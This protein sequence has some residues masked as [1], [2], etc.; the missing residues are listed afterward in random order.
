MIVVSQRL[1][2][3]SLPAFEITADARFSEIIED[4]VSPSNKAFMQG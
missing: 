1:D 4:A 3:T 2:E